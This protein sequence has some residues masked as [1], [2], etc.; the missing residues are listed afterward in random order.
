MPFGNFVNLCEPD[1]PTDICNKE[2]RDAIVVFDGYES[3]NTKDMV[4][5]RRA[6]GN[7]GT[8]VTFTA[9]M[10]ITMKKEHSY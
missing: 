6:K 9:D 4:H 3:T 8:T 1:I 7:G 5:Q 2:Y 10:P